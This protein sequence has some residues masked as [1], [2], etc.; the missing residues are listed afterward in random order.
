LGEKLEFD[1]VLT[2]APK[3]E[4]SDLLETAKDVLI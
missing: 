1:F 4:E 2:K 3:V